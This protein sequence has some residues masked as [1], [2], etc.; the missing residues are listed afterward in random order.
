ASAGSAP[1]SSYVTLRVY[2]GIP[3]TQIGREVGTSIRMIE[4]HYAGVIANWDGK[5][6]SAEAS[7]RAARKASIRPPRQTSERGVDAL[8][9]S[10]GSSA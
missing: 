1:R 10:K 4:Q 2:E 5:H 8:A 9:Y 7:I 3:L 6:R